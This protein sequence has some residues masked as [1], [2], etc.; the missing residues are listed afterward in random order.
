LDNL[1]S[2]FNQIW[3]PARKH[4]IFDTTDISRYQADKMD[5]EDLLLCLWFPMCF[6]LGYAELFWVLKG[7]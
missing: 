1:G 5:V 4:S 3:L 7:V 2:W 6:L